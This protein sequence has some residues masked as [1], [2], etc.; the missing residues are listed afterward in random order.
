MLKPERGHAALHCFRKS[1]SLSQ[2]AQTSTVY[3]LIAVGQADIAGVP[4]PVMLFFNQSP[5]L[6]RLGIREIDWRPL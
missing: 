6:E 4:G 1:A 3:R 2:A 5:E